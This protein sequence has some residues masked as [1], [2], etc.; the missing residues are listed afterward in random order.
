MRGGFVCA[1]YPPQRGT[2]PKPESKPAT[3]QIESKDPSYV[4]P[5]AYGMPQH[6]PYG[7]GQPSLQPKREPL[8]SYRGQPLRIEP[9]QG[10][11]LQSEDDR[12]TASTLPSASV[13]SPD[14]KLSALSSYTATANV[15]PT[16]VSAA[17]VPFPPDRTPKDY[18]RV[19]PLHD[20]SRGDGDLP[21]HGNTLPQIHVLHATRTNSPIAQPQTSGV[22]QPQT[23]GVQATAQLAPLP[24]AAVPL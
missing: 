14:N 18:Q 11:P 7:P 10:R 20:L 23:S 1:G 16:P 8:P 22:A 4:P 21:A 17:P 13:T 19:P 9:P 2:W 5:G 24:H 6:N 12:P 3:I 15:F